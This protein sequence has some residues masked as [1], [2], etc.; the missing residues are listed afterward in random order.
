MVYINPCYS[1]NYLNENLETG[2]VE[3]DQAL[4]DLVDFCLA[5]GI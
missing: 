1:L 3:R 5:Y 2:I 4:K